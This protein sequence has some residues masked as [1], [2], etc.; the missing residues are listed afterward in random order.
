MSRSRK[1][2]TMFCWLTLLPCGTALAQEGNGY[3][4]VFGDATGTIR[5]M[6]AP[7]GIPTTLYVVAKTA[8][9]TANGITGAEFRIEFQNP[10]GY[11]L[12]Y[13][14]PT[15]STVLG[16]PLSSTGYNISF[17]SCH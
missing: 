14:A 12:T 2:V 13:S 9:A 15:G 3:V 5:C 11:Y 4:G 16:D 6:Q 17:S 10:S 7:P 1:H 8:G